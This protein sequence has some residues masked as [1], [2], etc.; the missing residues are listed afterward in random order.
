MAVSKPDVYW[1]FA[2]LLLIVEYN[3]TITPLRAEFRTLEKISDGFSVSPMYR[4][5]SG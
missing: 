4:L 3:P 2:E 5:V 1:I